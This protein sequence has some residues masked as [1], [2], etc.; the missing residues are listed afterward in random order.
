MTFSSPVPV[1]ANTV[2]VAS[3]FAPNGHY[4]SDRSYFASTGVDN[5]PVHLLQDGVSGSNGLYSYSASSTFPTYP[6][7]ATNY[8][9]DVVFVAP[10]SL[11]V[12]ATTPPNNATGVYPGTVSTPAVLN[13]TFDNSLDVATVTGSSFIL[14][15]SS[16][17]VVPAT[18]GAA[19]N[20]AT[21][22]PASPLA[23][24]TTYTATLTTT[25]KDVDGNSLASNY[26]WSF[27]TAAGTGGCSSPPNAIVAEN[28]LPGN[29]ASEWDVSGAGDTSIQGFTTDI[30][31]NKGGTVN[32]KIKTDASAYRLDIYRM[33]YY[34]GMGARKVATVLPSASLPQTQPACLTDS[35][36]LIDCGNWALSAS[37]TVPANAT[38]GIYFARAVRTDTGGASHIFFIVRNDASHSDILFQTSDTTWQAYNNYGGNNLYTGNGAVGRAY[39]V[40]YNRP[41]NT[42]VYEAASWVFNG[43][44]PMVRWLEANGYDVSYFSEV[45]TER[46]AALMMNHKIWMSNSHDE[47]WS[48][49]QRASVQAARDAG[50]NLAFFSGNTIFW[51][52]RWETSIDG[53]GTPYRTMVCYKETHDNAKTDPIGPDIWTGT[54]RD[55]RFSPPADGG[56]PENSLKGNIFMVNGD[57]TTAITVPA[58]DGK[59]RFWRNTSVATLAAGQTATLAPGTLGSEVDVDEDN[60][61]RPAGL[62]G[63]STNPIN[64][65]SLYLLDYG[66]TYGAGSGTSRVTIYR[67]ASGALVFSTGSF[68]WSWGLDA[69]HDYSNVG[70]STD[71][72]MQQAT[73]NLFA[74][75]DV[76]PESLQA[77]LVAA[78]ISLDHTAP[79]STITSPLAGSNVAVGSPTTIQGTATDTGGGVVGGVEVSVDGGSTWHPASGRENWNYTWTPI[80]S[81]TITIKTRAVDDSGNLEIPGSG[82]TITAGSVTACSSNCRIWSPSA[83]PLNTFVGSDPNVELGVKF[84]ADVDGTI[85]GLLFYKDPGNT[86]V[87]VGNLWSSSGQLLATA[88]FT[89]ETTSGWQQVNFSPAVSV[90]ANTVYVASYHTTVGYYYDDQNY[91]T[92]Q[93]D[94]AP[95]HAL[96][97][98]VSGFNGV[99]AYGASSSFPNQGFNASN[100]WVDVLF[101]PVVANSPP[102]ASAVNITGVAEVGQT[103][104]GHYTY[105][106]ADNDPEGASTYRWLRGGVAIT[107]ATSATYVLA[108]ADQGTNISFEVT[109]VAQTGATVGAPVASAA[110]GPVAA[111]NTPPV[112]SNVYISGTAEVG[113]TLTGNYTYS[114]ADGNLEGASTFR[115]LRG[116]VAI[117]GATAKT[118]LLVAADQGAQ[119]SF[120]VTPVAQMG[121]AGVSVGSPVTSAAVG[122]VLAANTAPVASAVNITGVAQVGQTLTGHYTYSDADSDPQGV[123]TYRWLRNSVAISGATAATYMLVAADQGASI[124]FEVTPV[125]QTGVSPGAAVASP[126]VGPVVAA[127]TAP[128]ASAVNI[129]GVAQVGQ[130]LTGH[131]TYCDADSDPEGVS[132][133]R[134]LRNVSQSRVPRPRHICWWRRIRERISASK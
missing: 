22:T 126:A 123:S 33:G 35:T 16:N 47:Y 131:Y 81:G 79:S 67:A 128:V 132:T 73:V 100:Y 32:F 9:V 10:V 29:P 52:T 14:K 113:M 86:G 58:A 19:G 107:G 105:N 95:L 110:V 26:S 76:Q 96:Q 92:S 125:A 27:T 20:T 78:S 130:T 59:M 83:A 68:Q 129:T 112:A 1:T 43:E 111:A 13:A 2:Y 75:M 3:Y 38:S 109:P 71:L 17:A 87:H 70:S 50:V 69:N 21:L 36:G 24:S 49:G 77:G 66:S 48:A 57:Y 53:S 44:Y 127:N 91:F 60:G 39:K 56:L 4:N 85:S 6:D 124:S 62:F 72:R 122:P 133:Y 45:D 121:Q 103:L 46:N 12:T 115:W 63:V 84:K 114:D 18:V 7:Q 102:V 93:Y 117:S 88:T 64:T 8:W 98:G 120:E 61:F 25:I 54:W 11:H 74:D 40:S 82:I 89:G 80:T 65:S 90:T 99:Y 15:D 104:T 42:R 101:N 134:W 51:K 23:F 116:G 31:V 106:D 118:Y 37:W 119:I 108:A 94:N 34:G 97:D 28:C 41:F 5:Y 30:S 55:P